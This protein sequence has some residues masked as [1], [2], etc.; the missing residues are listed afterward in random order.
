MKWHNWSRANPNFESTKLATISFGNGSKTI[1]MSFCRQCIM[2][3]II[4]WALPYP[5]WFLW[6]FSAIQKYF[7]TRD[8]LSQTRHMS[9]EQDLGGICR[10]MYPRST[11][12]PRPSSW[13]PL[14]PPPHYTLGSF[15][16]NQDTSNRSVDKKNLKI[17]TPFCYLFLF[18]WIVH[19]VT[20]VIKCSG[21]LS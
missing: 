10:H 18:P 7:K 20:E 13:G 12:G 8:N 6:L 1:H 9:T 2:K 4:S 17:Q 21:R 14:L 11:F 5:L 19:N 16:N 15:Q 3:R